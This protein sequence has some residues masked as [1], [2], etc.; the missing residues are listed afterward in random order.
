L[1]E[2]ISVT[3][4]L[5]VMMLVLTSVLLTLRFANACVLYRKVWFYSF[6][7]H[8]IHYNNSLYRRDVFPSTHPL[9][10]P[11]HICVCIYIYIYI[12]IYTYTEF[13]ICLLWANDNR[14]SILPL[15]STS[16]PQPLLV[17][18]SGRK[19][20]CDSAPQTIRR[21]RLDLPSPICT[22]AFNDGLR[23]ISIAE[24]TL[25]S[26]YR[27]TKHYSFPAIYELWWRQL[28][29]IQVKRLKRRGICW[30]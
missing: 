29:I 21:E 11:W 12:Y 24:L 23:C 6:V 22:S 28:L 3:D 26:Q 5:L 30:L 4:I 20:R 18:W 27:N 16:H 1:S 19:T 25:Y 10:Y 9:S 17:F 15:A 2:R 14:T 13:R 8:W 7:C